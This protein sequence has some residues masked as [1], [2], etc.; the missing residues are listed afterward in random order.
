MSL[1]RNPGVEMSGGYRHIKQ[2]R[3]SARFNKKKVNLNN[4]LSTYKLDEIQA[5]FNK[6]IEAKE[7]IK[8]IVGLA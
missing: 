2:Y 5:A 6:A 4:G 7:T 8:V 3:S 1:K